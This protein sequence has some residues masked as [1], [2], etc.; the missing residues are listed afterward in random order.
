MSDIFK[1]DRPMLIEVICKKWQEIIPTVQSKKNK[2]GTLVSAPL[3][4]MYPFLSHK[5][6]ADNMIIDIL[7]SEVD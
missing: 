6:L 4:D 2:D 1:D 7:N 5:E 3:E